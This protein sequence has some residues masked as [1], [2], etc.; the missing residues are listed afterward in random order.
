VPPPPVP[1]ES[2]DPALANGRNGRW[3]W[4][5]AGLATILVLIVAAAVFIFI[6]QQP[7]TPSLVA[8]YAPADSVAYAEI[9]LDLPGDQ[10]ERLATFMSHFPGFADP[11]AFQ[12][13]IDESLA[14]ALR[15]S[16]T[17]LDWQADVQP[18]FGGMIGAFSNATESSADSMLSGVVVLS[19]KDRARLDELVNARTAEVG[20]QQQDYKGQTIWSATL[21]DGDPFHFAVTQDAFLASPRVEDLEAALDTKS[22]EL[23]GLAD[24]PF[25]T[26][27]L[28]KLHAD[29][30]GLAYYDYG[31]ALE[32][33]PMPTGGPSGVGVLP[34]QC[35]SD[36]SDVTNLKLLGEVRAE[37]DHLALNVRAQAPSIEGL[38]QLPNRNSTLPARMPSNTVAYL[39]SRAVGQ[40][41]KYY[42]GKLLECLPAEGGELDPNQIQQMIGT[43][44]EDY[45]DFVEDV[46]IGVTL[47]EGKFGGG[48]IATV[49]DENVARTRVERLLSAARLATGTGQGLTVE[50]QQHGDATITVINLG[51][52]LIPNADVP[53]IAITVS[54][55]RL[56]LG[57]GDFVTG[58]L[59]QVEA[60]S[61]ATAPRLQTALNSAGHENAALAYVDIAA[62]RGFAES[63][64]PA[65]ERTQYDT[66]MKPFID[67]ITQLVL[68]GVNEGDIYT[69]HV[70]LYV[71]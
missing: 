24:D 66:E 8:Q 52:Q 4:V 59:D 30:L 43:A 11:A 23:A 19:V 40:T 62:L 63:M 3:R 70:F 31:R 49:D 10:R 33:I 65:D 17:G 26:T 56:Y 57:V 13:K 1:V 16:G 27:Q 58:A 45:F 67:P 9:R 46:A 51:D 54:D 39:E 38:P 28:G 5:A 21:E 6:G 29:R 44:P 32:Q 64:I 35:L 48:L 55:G 25:F 71:E 47:S 15:T 20:A 14:N 69:S 2:T 41:I 68:V 61:L 36:L 12:Q 22:G 18:W 60:E 7:A 50:E 34:E 42:V 53:S 37:T